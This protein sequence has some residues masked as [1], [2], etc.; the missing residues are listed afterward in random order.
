[1]KFLFGVCSKGAALVFTLTSLSGQ[2]QS[3]LAYVAPGA[4]S[5]FHGAIQLSDGSFVIAGTAN[6]LAWLEPEVP[7]TE[8]PAT[9]VNT[10]GGSRV[11]FLLHITEDWSAIQAVAQLPAGAVTNLRRLRTTNVPGETTGVLHVSGATSGGHFIGRLNG[12]FLDQVPTAFVWVVNVPSGNNHVEI[13]AWDVGPAGDVVYVYGSEF[14]PQ[15]RFLDSSGNHRTVAGLRASHMVN[16]SRVQD[17][18]ANVPAATESR[19]FL[20]SDMFS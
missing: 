16:G 10:A 14:D 13:Q 18:G 17:L 9:G 20:P 5:V 8:I 12:N 6:D 19:I 7:V 15:V 4:S 1:M 11:S 2:I 3:V